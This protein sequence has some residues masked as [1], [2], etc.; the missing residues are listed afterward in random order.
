V[1]LLSAGWKPLRAGILK[2]AP[3]ALTRRLPQPTF[4]V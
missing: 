4:S 2:L 3:L 1:L